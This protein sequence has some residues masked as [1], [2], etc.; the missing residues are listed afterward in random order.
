MPLAARYLG[1]QST[2]FS[3]PLL[4]ILAEADDAFRQCLGTR[5]ADSSDPGAECCR[6]LHQAGTAHQ[7]E[8]QLVAAA[9]GLPHYVRQLM[10][11]K[12]RWIN[13]LTEPSILPINKRPRTVSHLFTSD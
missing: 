5:A 12:E 3:L 2:S 11:D 7:A 10:D 1:G 8:D 9:K 13:I 4:R 6:C